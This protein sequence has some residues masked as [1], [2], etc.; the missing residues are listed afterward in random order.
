[1]RRDASDWNSR[2]PRNAFIK[3]TMDVNGSGKALLL[4]VAAAEPMRL[5]TSCESCG[6]RYSY[7]GAAF[8]CPVC[9]A[10]SAH[11]TFTQT[12]SAVR[13][14]AR[15]GDLL[16]K[17]VDVDQ[18]EVLT[19][20]LLEKG[21]QDAVMSLQRLCEKM[22]LRFSVSFEIRRNA[23][24][25]LDEGSEL[26]RRATGR[27]FDELIAA[28]E[29]RK[30]KTYFQQRHLFAHCQGIVDNDYVTRS[31]DKTYAVGQ[32]LIITPDAVVEFADLVERLGQAV[33]ECGDRFRLETAQSDVAG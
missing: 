14:A 10:N 28:E 21:V 30:L 33:I 23:F 8:F 29:M 32:R 17:T 25:N 5:R 2:Q 11:H 1:M 27:G 9:G 12:L 31:G 18:A 20:A 3:I 6:C 4:P 24:Q 7:I 26:W 16:R 22:F 19:R 15:S 13:T